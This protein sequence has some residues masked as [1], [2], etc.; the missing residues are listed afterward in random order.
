M[1]KYGFYFLAAIYSV[2]LIYYLVTFTRTAPAGD[3]IG[4]SRNIFYSAGL[5]LFLPLDC[6]FGKNRTLVSLF[7]A[8]PFCF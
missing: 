5:F 1:L 6:C 2:Y 4:W 3:G 7:Y 8:Y